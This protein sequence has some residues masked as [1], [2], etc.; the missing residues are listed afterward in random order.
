MPDSYA[1]GDAVRITAAQVGVIR[2]TDPYK[3]TPIVLE[4]GDTGKINNVSPLPDGWFAVVPDV[5]AEA[6]AEAGLELEDGE[7]LIAPV[8]PSMIE[9]VR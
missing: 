4:A 7:L 3:F 6:L 5:T 2:T 1:D 8:H 9:L